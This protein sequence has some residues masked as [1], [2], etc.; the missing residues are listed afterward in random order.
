MHGLRFLH[1]VRSRSWIKPSQSIQTGDEWL[2]DTLDH[3]SHLLLTARVEVVSNEGSPNHIAYYAVR[4]Y[5]IDTLSKQTT[6]K[7]R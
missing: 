5:Q 1:S 4:V 3:V 2:P 6:N 7:L